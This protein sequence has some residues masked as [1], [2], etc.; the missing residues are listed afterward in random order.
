MIRLLFLTTISLICGLTYLQTN[1]LPFFLAQVS[2]FVAVVI[3]L[4]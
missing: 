1:L 2:F 4:N 3:E